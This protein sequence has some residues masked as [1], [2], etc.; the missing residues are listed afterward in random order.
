MSHNQ[1]SD[2]S[3]RNKTLSIL[4]LD[5]RM[6]EKYPSIRSVSYNAFESQTGQTQVGFFSFI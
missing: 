3:T 5:S 1:D 4:H 6:S 2:R